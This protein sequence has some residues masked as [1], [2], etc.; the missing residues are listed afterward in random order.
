MDNNKQCDGC[1]VS[2][3]VPYAAF[4]AVSAR[5]ERNIRRLA[6]IIVFLIL[7]LIGSNIAWLCYESQFEDVTTDQTVT[8]DTAGGGDNNFVGGDLVGTTNG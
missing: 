1:Q 8:Q 3:N 7:A 6:L 5:A 4:E 2:A